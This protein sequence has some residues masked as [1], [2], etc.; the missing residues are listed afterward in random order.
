MVAVSFSIVVASLSSSGF[1]VALVSAP[2]IVA[3]S[4][5]MRFSW[6]R[7]SIAAAALAVCAAV[8]VPLAAQSPIVFEETFG[9]FKA[10]KRTSVP[11]ALSNAPPLS[12]PLSAPAAPLNEPPLSEPLSAPAASLSAPPAILLANAGQAGPGSGQPQA[13]DSP[14]PKVSVPEVP[15]ASVAPGSGRLYIWP[16]ALKL[17]M[18]RPLLGYGMDTLTYVFPQH[19]VEKI[20]GMGHYNV[21][22]TKPHNIYIGYAYG[23]GIPA[24]LSFLAVCAL[25]LCRFARFLARSRRD[26][27]QPPAFVVCFMAAWVAY[28]VQG[29]VNDD[30]ISTAPIWWTLGGIAFGLSCAPPGAAIGA[31]TGV[32]TS[33]PSSAPDAATAA[34]AGSPCGDAVKS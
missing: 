24:L 9:M 12:E 16:R 19:D 23:A 18:E 17:I 15:P 33:M 29:F 28:L 6:R 10:L 30:L 2:V 14:I 4:L 31:P 22:I 32:S 27:I 26:C 11:Q 25:S 7:V 34:K 3:A 5:A 20:A 8:Y 1:L 21:Y 13:G